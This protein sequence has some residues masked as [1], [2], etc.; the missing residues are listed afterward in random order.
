[1]AKRKDSNKAVKTGLLVLLGGFAYSSY[2]LQQLHEEELSAQ[3]SFADYEIG[4]GGDRVVI[5]T[6]AKGLLAEGSTGLSFSQKV[7]FGIIDNIIPI[8]VLL[9]G[10][11]IAIFGQK[12]FGGNQSSSNNSSSST[13]QSSTSNT[14]VIPKG[15]TSILPAKKA[16]DNNLI[17]I[18]LVL[19]FVFS[20]EN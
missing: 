9:A 15:T 17:I 13:S 2:R 6:K 8:V 18:I 11:G 10:S 14:S 7:G 19:L 4:G 3:Q 12:L 5:T 16:V 20:K 1:M